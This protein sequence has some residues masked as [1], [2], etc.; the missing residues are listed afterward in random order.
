[1]PVIMKRIVGEEKIKIKKRDKDLKGK[2][3]KKEK[4]C[5]QNEK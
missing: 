2:E 3:K 5:W 4:Q 1:M